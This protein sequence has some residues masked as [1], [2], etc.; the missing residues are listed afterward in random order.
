LPI[1]PPLGNFQLVLESGTS[2]E[3]NNLKVVSREVADKNNK[4][5]S[6]EKHEEKVYLGEKPKDKV[7]SGEKLKGKKEEYQGSSKSHKKKDIKKKRIKKVVY[8]ETDTS[9]SPSTSGTKSTSSKRHERKPV[10]QIP[11]SY[12]CIPKHAPLLLVPLEKPS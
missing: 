9:S 10:N 11:F 7:S 2:L 3:S 12:P 5:S 1:H 4:M 8:Y 6:G